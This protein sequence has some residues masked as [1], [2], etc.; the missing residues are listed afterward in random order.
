MKSLLASL[1]IGSALIAT[2][3]YAADQLHIQ[4]P[5]V[6]AAPPAAPALG[7]YMTLHNPDSKEKKIV[8][9]S[10]PLFSK[11]E[12]HETVQQDG[13]SQ[14]RPKPQLAIA[15]G[16]QVK[17]AP[18]GLHIMLIGPKKSLQPKDSVPLTLK[19]A[20]GSEQSLSAEVRAGSGVKAGNQKEMEKESHDHHH[21]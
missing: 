9:A 14:M 2:P 4:D 15:P 1:L 3:A 21:H 13:K 18:G 17:M 6:R 5:W 12:I 11:V 10:S 7:G 19:F 20:D 8:G 16:A